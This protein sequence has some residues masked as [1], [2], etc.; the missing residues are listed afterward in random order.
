MKCHPLRAAIF[1]VCAARFA[2][3]DVVTLKDGRVLEGQVL[4]D[5]GKTLKIKMKKGT[6][7][8]EHK[9]VASVVE[10]PTPE[11][12][13]KERLAKLDPNNAV[14]QFDLGRWAGGRDLPDQAVQ[15][16]IAA[17]KIDPKLEGI[18]AELTK[19]DYHLV[20][21]HW[22]DPDTYYPSIGYIK[23][24]NRWCSPAE[25]AYRMG[26]REVATLA[27]ARDAAKSALGGGS[28]KVKK[29]ETRASAE[30]TNI[31]RIEKL[32]VKAT[33]D[34]AAVLERVAAAEGKVKAA[35]DKLVAVQ[36]KEKP[37]EGDPPKDASPAMKDA[38]KKL[39]AARTAA[40]KESKALTAVKKTSTDLAVEK[41]AAQVRLKAIETEKSAAETEIVDLEAEIKRAQAAVDEA[42]AAAES[43]KAAWE[44]AK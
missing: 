36:E 18:P 44:K 3:A 23:F 40:E 8:L 15:H 13:Y 30:R 34:Q 16:L 1:V 9:D 17:W 38:E 6:M 33:A 25:H 22:R 10:K 20:D 7:T 41:S 42:T 2:A 5:D 27:A 31:E 43:L 12:E 11:E 19:Q 26:L 14:S 29:I 24:E 28:G 4:E 21:G 39:I 35:S 32:I 37:K